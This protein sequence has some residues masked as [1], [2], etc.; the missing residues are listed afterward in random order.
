MAFIDITT[1]GTLAC[2]CGNAPEA[3]GFDPCT[4][5]GVIDESL[6]DADSDANLHYICN[7]CDAVSPRIV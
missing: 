1:D 3:D 7:R 4:A 2:E 5:D 6:L